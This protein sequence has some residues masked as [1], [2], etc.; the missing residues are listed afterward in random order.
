M[1]ISNPTHT[2]CSWCPMNG[3]EQKVIQQGDESKPWSHGLC[4]ECYKDLVSDPL[5]RAKAND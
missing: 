5:K 1:Q 2:V 4:L 3:R